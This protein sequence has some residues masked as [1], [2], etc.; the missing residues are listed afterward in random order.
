[1]VVLVEGGPPGPS[2]I[3]RRD[4]QSIWNFVQWSRSCARRGSGC[5][6]AW[7]SFLVTASRRYA[8]R[9]IGV[10]VEGCERTKKKKKDFDSWGSSPSCLPQ[11][12]AAT[13]CLDPPSFFLSFFLGAFT[14]EC[15]LSQKGRTVLPMPKERCGQWTFREYSRSGYCIRGHLQ[16]PCFD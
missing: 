14:A 2:C 6:K 8:P 10:W 16:G 7:V 3:R 5:V 1:M 12:A 15:R 11:G 4:K 9:G 13:L